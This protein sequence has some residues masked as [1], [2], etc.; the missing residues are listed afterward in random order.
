MRRYR[1]QDDEKSIEGGGE[2]ENVKAAWGKGW[3]GEGW[4][5][6]GGAAR[7]ERGR[8]RGGGGMDEGLRIPMIHEVDESEKSRRVVDVK[9]VGG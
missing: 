5:R 6:C 2:S 3:R 1:V 8:R 4:E 7:K 9:G